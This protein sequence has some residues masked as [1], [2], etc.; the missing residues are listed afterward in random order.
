MGSNG[1]LRNGIRIH[2]YRQGIPVVTTVHFRLKEKNHHATECEKDC[3]TWSPP[4]GMWQ[5]NYMTDILTE[6][7][8]LAVQDIRTLAARTR[9]DC[10]GKRDFINCPAR[11]GVPGRLDSE[12]LFNLCDTMGERTSR[13]D[14][15]RVSARYVI[16]PRRRPQHNPATETGGDVVRRSVC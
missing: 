3:R 10:R 16:N 14:K 5:E 4:A 13:N 11:I 9:P 12:C 15:K 1:P 7:I 6:K 2:R 8:Y